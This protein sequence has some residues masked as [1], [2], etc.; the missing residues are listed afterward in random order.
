MPLLDGSEK[1]DVMATYGSGLE[2]KNRKQEQIHE[3]ISNKADS[4]VLFHPF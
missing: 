4:N 1:C 3:Y 2:K